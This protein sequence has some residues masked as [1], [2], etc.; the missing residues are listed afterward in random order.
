M[1]TV[2][3]E[4]LTVE[5]VIGVRDWERKIKQRVVLDLE[6]AWDIR[7]AA[8]TDDLADALDYAAV[9]RRLTDFVS[10]SRFELIETLAARCADLVRSEYAVPWL[11]LKLSKPG[12]VPNAT[13]VGVV[14]ERGERPA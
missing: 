2:V 14:I 11:R 13:T 8:S 3:I 12:A 7:R 5:C 9:S 4:G 6:L 10:E 1:D